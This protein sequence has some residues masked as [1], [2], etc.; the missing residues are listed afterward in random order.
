M[1]L[2]FFRPQS[3]AP[4]ITDIDL[5]RLR[6]RGI[7]AVILD[8]DNTIVGFRELAPLEEDARW[9]RQAKEHG[10]QVVELQSGRGPNR[11]AAHRLYE[12][13]GFRIRDTDVFRIVL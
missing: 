12:R 10:V 5:A 6:E 11:E 8:L 9:V 4:R 1:M 3:Y 7:R 2:G 13:L